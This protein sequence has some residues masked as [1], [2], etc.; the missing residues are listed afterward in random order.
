MTE[1]QTTRYTNTL[2][3]RDHS[4]PDPTTVQVHA[5]D[6]WHTSLRSCT[7]TLH[8]ER[9]SLQRHQWVDYLDTLRD[10]VL[11]LELLLAWSN[12]SSCAWKVRLGALDGLHALMRLN[13]PLRI[14]Q[15]KQNDSLS[16]PS[17]TKR[18][19][20]LS[21]SETTDPTRRLHATHIDVE[22]SEHPE[23]IPGICC[24]CQAGRW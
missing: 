23:R 14:Q 7:Q 4:S 19:V 13:S 3:F 20:H 16:S 8:G 10:L 18:L 22:R 9:G 5:H 21:F 12:L 17:A 1:T 2:R 15:P 11:P 24:P 6:S